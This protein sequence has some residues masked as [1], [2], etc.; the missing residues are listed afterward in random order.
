MEPEVL[1]SLITLI[2]SALGTFA[3]IAVNAKLT[4]F[5]I[6][7]LEKKVDK[8][9][10]VIERTVKLEERIGAIDYRLKEIESR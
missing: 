4:N 1:V 3:G 2:G 5:R 10:N 7:Q 6:E 9:N 8:H